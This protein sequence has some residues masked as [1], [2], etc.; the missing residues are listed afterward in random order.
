MH[1]SC[2]MRWL[3]GFIILLL[4]IVLPLTGYN[5]GN[6]YA[7]HVAGLVGI[8][9]ILCVG[10]NITVGYTGL[11]DLGFMAFCAIGAYTAALLSIHGISFWITLPISMFLGGFIRYLLGVPVLRLRGD[12]L[13]IVTLAFGEI[14]RLIANNF[15]WLTNGPK[16]L[17]RVGE[18]I[19]EIRLFS[20]VFKDDLQFYYLILFF[21]I[22]TI[23][24]SYRL[25]H[26]RIGR[27]L[28]AIRED[29][30]AAKLSG[31]NVPQIKSIAFVLSGMFGALAGAIYVHWIGFISPEMF[32]F[33]ESVLLVSMLV[34]G[35]M[36]NIGGA[37]LGVVLLVGIP[38]ILRPV[39]GTKFVDYRMIIFGLIMIVVIIFRPEGIWKSKRR[40]LELKEQQI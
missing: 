17:P 10:L 14:V 39:L 36:G 32:T 13:A 29:E 34:I 11:L 16:G 35:G 12:Y 30:L 3:T 8:Y 37:I 33:W 6:Y 21:L 5:C 1:N 22:G 26:S 15:D 20:L 38:E 7:I 27:A 24:I 2:N 28:V 25:E 31:I 40:A 19:A 4:L 9:C 23:L 18:K